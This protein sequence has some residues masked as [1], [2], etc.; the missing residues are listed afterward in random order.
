[1][2]QQQLQQ[3]Q[4]Q[5]NQGGRVSSPG[6]KDLAITRQLQQAAEARGQ[7]Q[8]VLQQRKLAEQQ[9]NEQVP[10]MTQITGGGSQNVKGNTWI[11]RGGIKVDQL[12]SHP[13]TDDMIKPDSRF[14]PN[15][16]L[17]GYSEGPLNAAQNEY[18]RIEEEIH[19]RHEPPSAVKRLNA[20]IMKAIETQKRKHCGFS[21]ESFDEALRTFFMA[22][23]LDKN[24]VLNLQ[25]VQK[26]AE[27]VSGSRLHP[28][29][30]K[31][32]LGFYDRN[33]N[34]AVAYDEF[35]ARVCWDRRGAKG[36]PPPTPSS[37][38]SYVPAH[39]RFQ[40]RLMKVVDV[41]VKDGTY[42]SKDDALRG[43]FMQYDNDSNGKLQL[44]ELA[45]AIRQDLELDFT[46]REVREVMGY[47]D[48]DHSSS[49]SYNEIAARQCWHNRSTIPPPTPRTK[50]PEVPP[51]KRFQRRL[52][53]VVRAKKHD[54][55]YRTLDDALHGIFIQYDTDSNGRLQES[56]MA[57]A[58]QRHLGLKMTRDQV[59]EVMRTFDKDHSASCSYKELS[60]LTCWHKENKNACP[61]PTPGTLDS[62][63]PADRRFTRRLLQMAECKVL[64]GTY[65]TLPDAVRGVFI[66]YDGDSNG[67]IQLPEL[68]KC[69]VRSLNLPWGADWDAVGAVMNKFDTNH[70]GTMSWLE[71][72]EEVSTSP[73]YAKILAEVKAAQQSGSYKTA[74]MHQTQRA[75][76]AAPIGQGRQSLMAKCPFAGDEVEANRD[77]MSRGSIHSSMIG[78][79]I[80][81]TATPESGVS[82]VGTPDPTSGEGGEAGR[83]VS[84]LATRGSS[85]KPGPSDSGKETW[86][87]DEATGEWTAKFEGGERQVVSPG[88][89][90]ATAGGGVQM[91]ALESDTAVRMRYTPVGGRE[92]KGLSLQ[93]RLAR[94]A[95]RLA[96]GDDAEFGEYGQN[97]VIASGAHDKPTGATD[98]YGVPSYSEG[99]VRQ[100]SMQQNPTA[101]PR[102]H[103]HFSASS[104]R[105]RAQTPRTP[106]TA[107]SRASSRP[108]TRPSPPSTGS[109]RNKLRSPPS[110]STRW[111]K[112][113]AARQREVAEVRDLM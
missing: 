2:M 59:K 84:V 55:T 98:F 101:V 102:R 105:S 103:A 19:R 70:R 34:G 87:L 17:T 62:Q 46:D 24:G 82:P 9:Q 75:G 106:S 20:C 81:P 66:Q 69:I 30:A 45:A 15:G 113:E 92:A 73:E 112:A 5:I 83:K 12:R 85:A 80:A 61:P 72:W 78:S 43:L 16:D 25:D 111:A 71:N 67:M 26:I 95:R 94:E 86:A 13:F 31:D 51:T 49:A 76:I 79:T 21:G 47:Y 42:R 99:A 11:D 50:N 40:T 41:K 48:K 7:E 52:L 107:Q 27:E 89:G 44:P 110:A 33:G 65:R 56:E 35:A 6:G 4:Q 23:D 37:R 57:D 91:H 68:R 10:T 96:E 38:Y 14:F 36:I 90:G 39:D 104:A 29:E 32:L 18:D 3:V 64:D 8:Q 22:H 63:I 54:Q 109:R 53:Q 60:N 88:D 108:R 1:M 77:S 58:I 28:Q 97:G 100:L 74:A 93:Q